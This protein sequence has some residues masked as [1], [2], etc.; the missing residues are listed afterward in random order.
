MLLYE[1]LSQPAIFF[2]VFSIGLVS[3]LLFDLKSYITF[4]CASNKIVSVLLD[5]LTTLIVFV[6]LF[7][8]NLY[9]NYGEFRFY[10]IFAFFAGLLIER[11][12]LGIFVAKI[13]SW[14]YNKFRN[15][16]AK[17]YE[18]REKKKESITNS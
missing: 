7:L 5:V 3:G 8:S 18:R 16:M 9:F 11:V 12:T 2:V 10:V 14:C 13:C 4:L 17:I 6:I 1:T 15:L